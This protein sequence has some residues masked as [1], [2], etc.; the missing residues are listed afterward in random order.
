MGWKLTAAMAM[1]I[2][3][4]GCISREGRTSGI[5][6]CPP[7]EIQV[8]NEQTQFQ[9]ITWQASCRGKSFYCTG[10]SRDRTVCSPLLDKQ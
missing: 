2:V 7:D 8:S 9:T 10:D 4:S 6:G 3:L 5:I 1:A